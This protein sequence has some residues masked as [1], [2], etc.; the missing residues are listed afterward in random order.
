[1][2]EQCI[3]QRVFAMTSAWMN[4]E[5]GRFID[6]NEIVVFEKSLQRNCFRLIVDLFGRWLAESN[7]IAIADEIARPRGCPVERHESS[8]DQ[9]L[10]SRARI[11]RQLT[12][13]KA[14]ETKPRIFFSRYQFNGCRSFHCV[15]KWPVRCC[16]TCECY[17]RIE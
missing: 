13:E 14:I 5:A 15:F 6:D 4:N 3:D 11:S 9:L 2:I 16:K 10:E 12:G 1:M 7:F 8:T 17:S